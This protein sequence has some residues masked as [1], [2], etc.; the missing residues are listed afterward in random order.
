M[1]RRLLLI[2]T[3]GRLAA[4]DLVLPPPTA[5]IVHRDAARL[6]CTLTLPAGS[7]A[8]AI[9]WR[10]HGAIAVRGAAWSVTWEPL[11]AEAPAPL[12]DGLAVL[13]AERNRLAGARGAVLA[14]R[15][16]H[17]RAGIA[18]RERLPAAAAAGADTAAWQASLDAWLAQ[19]AELDAADAADAA[20]RAA[21]TLRA[22]GIARDVGDW[23]MLSGP[24]A[25]APLA[26]ED[27]ARALSAP[28]PQASRRVLHLALAAEAEV[29]IEIALPSVRWEPSA[30]LALRGGEARLV[31]L[32]TLH[33][34]ADLDLGTLPVVVTT[35]ASQ[36]PLQG[37]GE[38]RMRLSTEAVAN[39]QRRQ[40][41]TGSAVVEWED[42][43]QAPAARIATPPAS[44]PT[45]NGVSEDMV[46]DGEVPSGKP[47]QPA[48]RWDLGP[49][50]LPRDQ[51]R[52]TAERPA[53][54][55]TITGDEWAV[56][57]AQSPVA[58]R[59]LGVRLDGQ[60]LLAGPLTLVVDDAIIGI[61]TI[62]AHAPG[63][64][65]TLRAGED[66]AVFAGPAVP[67]SVPPAEQSERR[68]RQGSSFTLRNFADAPR[69]VAVY[70]TIPVSRSAELTV[71]IAPES[72][73]GATA[74][75]PGVLRWQVELPAGGGQE[76]SLGWMLQTS[77]GL[78]L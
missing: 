77:G 14:R 39:S 2:A 37:P 25:D 30:V 57:P 22:E 74:T 16:A 9:P 67:W 53:V 5:L 21:L 50:A 45:T 66:A 59:R 4:A 62:A 8:V 13:V 42:V 60:P 55:L 33:K 47:D 46:V 12:P 18:I 61:E 36:P 41:Q 71:T 3:L 32:V 35:T 10:D 68:Q 15:A 49:L 31:R 76:F 54:A 58:Q 51:E 23:L 63:T 56:I 7:H 70:Q 26:R 17:E 29:A 19:R 24:Q 6:V 75:S 48:L 52:I 11:P 40:V 20:A 1:M 34:P 38:P 64:Q 27:A 69:T 28:R 65:L 44:K 78:K 72:S 43:G 73:A